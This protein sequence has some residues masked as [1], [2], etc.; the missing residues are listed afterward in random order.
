MRYFASSSPEKWAGFKTNDMHEQE[1]KTTSS[2]QFKPEASGLQVHLSC[3][4]E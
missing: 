4:V 3:P 2:I 1:L